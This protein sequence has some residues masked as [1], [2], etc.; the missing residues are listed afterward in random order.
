MLESPSQLC[1][2]RL[3]KDFFRQPE[4]NLVLPLHMPYH[5]FGVAPGSG[6]EPPARLQVPLRV[7]LSREAQLIGEP[8]FDLMLVGEHVEGTAR[9]DDIPPFENR[10]EVGLFLPVL[11]PDRE[12]AD[13]IIDLRQGLGRNLVPAREPQANP[14]EGA[15][16]LLDYSVLVFEGV[17]RT[18]HNVR[19]RLSGRPGGLANPVTTFQG[20]RTLRGARLRQAQF[21]ARP[22]YALKSC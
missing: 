9:A 20:A 7:F 11:L 14:V 10:E 3:V 15:Q 22:S 5:E 21:R 2:V 17:Y 12:R 19:L 4:K 13:E 8:A 1:L 6:H 18:R 16:A